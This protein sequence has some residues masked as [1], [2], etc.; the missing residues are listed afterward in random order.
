MTFLVYF[1]RGISAWIVYILL[2]KVIPRDIGFKHWGQNF[3]S[4]KVFISCSLLSYWGVPYCFSILKCR[5][6]T[7]RNHIW[8]IISS[9]FCFIWRF[10]HFH[11]RL[12]ESIVACLVNF[13]AYFFVKRISVVTS[14]ANCTLNLLSRA[15][16]DIFNHLKLLLI[17]CLTEI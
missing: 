15:I 14:R 7:F 3:F 6:V 10:F 1:W 8:L 2:N 5:I 12:S 17:T 9:L 4:L 13:K 16:Q 11:R